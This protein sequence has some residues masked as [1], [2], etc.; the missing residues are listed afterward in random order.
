MLTG[1]ARRFAEAAALVKA[2]ETEAAA[3]TEE[4]DDAG[5]G[6]AAPGASARAGPAR[7]RPRPSAGRPGRMKELEDRQKSRATRTKRDVL[8]RALVDL[9]GFYRDVLVIAMGAGSR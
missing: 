8:D 4:L 2:A 1:S 3:I 7:A 5:A 9:S 6:G